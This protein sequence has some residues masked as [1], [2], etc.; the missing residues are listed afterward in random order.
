[1]Q[2]QINLTFGKEAL[3][4]LPHKLKARAYSSLFILVDEHTQSYCLEP[5]LNQTQ[6][7]DA[8]VLQMKAG[9]E[10]KQLQTCEKLWQQLSELGADRNS[11]LLNLGGGVVTDLG[12]FVACT[13][14]RGIDF[15]NIPTSL[16]AM[17]DASVGGKTGIDFGPLKNQIGIIE[18][19][20]EVIIDSQWLQT[21]PE[22]EIRSGFAEMLKHGL[23]A[24]PDYWKEL[25]ELNTLDVNSLAPL[26][27][28]SIAVKKEVV[29]TDPKERGLRKILNYG[30]TL[31]HAI[32]SY[33][34]IHPHKK[35]LLHGEA[36][37]VGM[38]L[39]AF[40]SMHCCGLNPMDAAAIKSGFKRFYPPVSF[41]NEEI[42]EI[43]DLLRH[44][45]KNK[46]GRVHF[47]L[48]KSIGDPQ[49]DVE[50]PQELFQK[51]FEYYSAP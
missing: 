42:N 41:S 24:N 3:A 51:A 31:G 1:M 16:L 27:E 9:E 8:H 49:M 30:H 38:V 14:K 6:L 39:E 12:G 35:R 34:L 22:V 29:E 40:L 36:I 48:L 2:N 17:V 47:V 15:Y 13:F 4:E 46:A 32:E 37:A 5:F 21:L 19:P 25:I 10:N 11:A 33:F 23:I 44:D 45:K 26:I 43:V 18:E 50:V 7:H 28:S 20:Q